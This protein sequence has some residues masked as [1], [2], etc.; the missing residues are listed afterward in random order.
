MSIEELMR[1]DITS[2]SRRQQPAS[3]APAAVFVITHD[4]I[5]RSGM[6]TIADV[7]RLAP[8][9][10]VAQVNSNKWAVSARGFNGLYAN[11]L[12][13]LVD[14]RSIYNRL[15][16]GVLWDTGDLLLDDIDRIEVIRGPGAALWGA[17][18]VNGVI[19]IVTKASDD[20]QGGLVRVDEGT[21]GQQ[22]TLRYGG[23][24]AAATYRVYA[25]WTGSSE[26]VTA[27]GELARDASNSVTTGFRTD[28]SAA[29][30]AFMLQGAATVGSAQSLWP[31]LDPLTV[32]GQPIA[33]D[34]SETWASHVL[35]RWTHTRA[36]GGSLQ[37][38]TYADFA[39]RKEPVGRYRRQAFDIDSQYQTRIGSRHDVVAGAGYRFMDERLNG[40][41]GFSITPAQ[42]RSSLATVFVQDAISLFFGPGI[43]H[44][45][46]P[47]AVRL[48]C[49]S[50]CAAKRP[51]DVEAASA[52]PHLGVGVACGED[53]LADR[54]RAPAQL[55]RSTGT[56]RLPTV[57]DRDR[58]PRLQDRTTPR[59]RSRLSPG[60]RR[61]SLY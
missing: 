46:Q 3:D 22:G 18:A 44:A 35:G 26:S 7:L 59:R 6:K 60:D 21:S 12:L 8:G 23:K 34:A 15:F 20:T 52:A 19:N 17:N 24:L 33:T 48:G 9:L 14:G 29:P 40:G 36:S 54:P 49:R 27:T 45:W 57:C 42:D 51:R 4:A 32:A 41:I 55:R 37:V 1:I 58:Q 43:V 39:D 47:A 28:W 56:R 5:R 13:V 10:N 11:R 31:N 25:Q 2:V 50:R 38:Q 30:G 53:T 16:A 61:L